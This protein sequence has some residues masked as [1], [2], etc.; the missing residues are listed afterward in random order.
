MT[1]KRA[2]NP[3]PMTVRLSATARKL[4]DR[5]IKEL[6]GRDGPTTKTDAIE[7]AIRRLADELNLRG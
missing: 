1:N 5:I 4:L 3:K 6:N 2:D 7:R